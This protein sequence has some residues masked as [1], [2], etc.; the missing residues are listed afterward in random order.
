MF[1]SVTSISQLCHRRRVCCIVRCVAVVGPS[2]VAQ[3]LI[4]S[5][6]VQENLIGNLLVSQWQLQAVLGPAVC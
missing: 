2:S 6:S 3:W 1:T 4:L 5:V